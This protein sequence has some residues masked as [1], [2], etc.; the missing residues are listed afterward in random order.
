MALLNC[1]PSCGASFARIQ[2]FDPALERP[3]RLSAYKRRLTLPQVLG[4]NPICTTSNLFARKAVFDA[5]GSFEP[6]LTHGED[7]EWV[8]RVLATTKWTVRGVQAVLVHYRTSPAGLSA[9]LDRMRDGW[10]HMFATVRSYAPQMSDRLEGHS[11]AL[12][13]RFLARRAL[14]TGQTADC[15]APMLRAWRASPRTLL[16]TQPHRTAMTML[17]IFAASIPGNPIRSVL[18]R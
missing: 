12:F 10:M 11:T 13:Y 16:C 1:D 9:D 2:F 6:S 4:E 14:R 15:V 5:V 3:G 17:G 7:Q 18:A 8:A